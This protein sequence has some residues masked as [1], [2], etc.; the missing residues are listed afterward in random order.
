MRT[1][2]AFEGGAVV[3]Q[4]KSF[5]GSTE[6]EVSRGRGLQHFCRFYLDPPLQFPICNCADYVE[7][8]ER[9]EGLPLMN[10]S[11]EEA[12]ELFRE[13]E[14]WFGD[15][16]QDK[17]KANLYRGLAAMAE[18]LKDMQESLDHLNQNAGR[19]AALGAL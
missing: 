16:R 17:E 10:R 6:F 4:S 7:V 2:E 9:R 14:T 19:E 1:V 13:N 5:A 11:I 18:A 8:F 3:P 12:I 15:V